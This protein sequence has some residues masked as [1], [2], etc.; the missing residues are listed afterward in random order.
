MISSKNWLFQKRQGEETGEKR[1]AGVELSLRFFFLF[2]NRKWRRKPVW[3]LGTE[4]AL[5]AW[6]ECCNSTGQAGPVGQ[7][8]KANKVGL[9]VQKR[10]RSKPLVRNSVS[11]WASKHTQW[12]STSAHWL[13]T[14]QLSCVLLWTYCR[15]ESKK[16]TTRPLPFLL[17]MNDPERKASP[18]HASEQI[19]FRPF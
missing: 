13:T 9:Y 5:Q 1:D 18:V 12:P 7:Q 10:V 15:L 3:K 2:S 14:Q 6:R 16:H 17:W 11:K 19:S 8:I 4:M